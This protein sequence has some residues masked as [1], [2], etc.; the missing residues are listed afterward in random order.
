M[1]QDINTW[2]R[3]L[4]LGQYCDAFAAGDVDL[5]VLP[6]LTETDLRE[7]GVSLGHRKIIL[8]AVAESFGG[9][10]S[11]ANTNSLHA[12]DKPLPRAP[13]RAAAGATPAERPVL[14][15]G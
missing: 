12:N 7:L 9:A 1:S 10:L 6:H 8:A 13:P 11:A 5:R 3:A 4:G 2:L 15:S 14:R